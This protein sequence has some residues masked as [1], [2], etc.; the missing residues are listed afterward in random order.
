MGGALSHE[1]GT[2]RRR[3]SSI[4]TRFLN[5]LM[6]PAGSRR[7]LVRAPLPEIRFVA[8]KPL[9]SPDDWKVMLAGGDAASKVRSIAE[10]GVPAMQLAW[11]RMLLAGHGVAQDPVEALKW[12]SLAAEAGDVVA[13]NM[14]G[15][16]HE[17]GWGTVAS[18]TTAAG[19]Y[20]RSAERG[21]AWAQFNL[22]MLLFDGNG[23]AEDRSGALTLFLRAARG[24]NPKAMNMLGRYCEEAWAVRER[25]ASAFHWYRRSALGGDFRGQFNYGR[26]LFV[27][28]DRQQGLHW[29]RQ[30][31]E[32]GIPVFRANVAADLRDNPDPALRALG[33]LAAQPQRSTN[34]LISL[35]E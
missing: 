24:G 27:R 22:A 14:V 17:M 20:R 7:E 33:E 12:F 26:M 30:S 5:S 23:V 19:F 29:V 34:S 16:C 9:L 31:I 10:S 4:A 25:A 6:P 15:R 35:E 1:S 21:F 18:A 32:N 8:R 3:L 28:G 13:M 11:G 2:P